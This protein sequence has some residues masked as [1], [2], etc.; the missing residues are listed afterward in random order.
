VVL[1]LWQNFPYFVNLSFNLHIKNEN[2]ELV[3]I[4][5]DPHCEYSPKKHLSWDSWSKVY[6]DEYFP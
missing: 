5:F 4:L 3:P 1:K 2:V 6:F